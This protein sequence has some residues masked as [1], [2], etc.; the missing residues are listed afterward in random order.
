MRAAMIRNSMQIMQ[1]RLPYDASRSISSSV[2]RC[3]AMKAGETIDGL[4]V[5]KGK[6]P[7][8]VLKREEYPEWVGE[9]V[10][11]PQTLAALRRIPNE[12]ATLDEMKRYLKLTRRFD[13]KEK[14]QEASK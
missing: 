6:D 10:N 3:Q 12:D 9:L 8:V 5:F 2:P 1:Q 4:G 7:P 11:P 13:I 14:N